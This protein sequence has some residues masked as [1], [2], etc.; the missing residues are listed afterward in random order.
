M[1]DNF[2][3]FH[4]PFINENLI[5]N[6]VDA[7]KSGWWTMGPRVQK[8]EQEFSELMGRQTVAVNSWTAAAHLALEAIGLKEGDEVIV[9]AITFTATAEVVCYFKAT[10]IIVD[11]DPATGNILPEE[12]ERKLTPKTKVVI[13]VHY[14]GFASKMDE[15]YSICENRARV[16]EDAAHA[17]PTYYNDK[18][19]GSF[20][21]ITGF[22]FYVTKPLAAGEG[23]LICTDDERIIERA[24]IMRLHGIDKDSWK[25][26]TKDGKW[27]YEVVSPGF[28]YNWTDI[29]AAIALEQ[30]KL[31]DDLLK[32]RVAIAAKYNDA[33]KNYDYFEIPL[34]EEHTRSAWHIYPL[35]LNLDSLK[36]DRNEFVNYLTDMGIGTSVH[37]IPL[38]MHPFYKNAFNLNSADYPNSYDFYRREISLPIWPGMDDTHIE[39]VIQ[40]VIKVAE[41]NRR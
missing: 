7:V 29:Q 36:I 21:D 25:R 19:V 12:I 5:Q 16:I 30:L 34:E 26:Y 15:I 1:S 4:K 14:G 11:V 38:Y 27:Y 2:L 10:P 31:T 37:F 28:K 13:P 40:S 35:K 3:P 32:M 8:F 23:G 18:L 41:Q 6:V 33:F 39:R 9:P 24:K 20:G 17:I 22:S